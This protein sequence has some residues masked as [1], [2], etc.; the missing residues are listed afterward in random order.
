MVE[1]LTFEQALDKSGAAKRNLLLGNGFSIACDPTIFNYESLYGEAATVIQERMPEVHKL[2]EAQDTKDFEAIIR[3]LEH[4]C[5]VLPCYLTTD[6]ETTSKI[7][8]HSNQLKELLIATIA[9]NHP[10]FPANIPNEK[11]AA[12]RRFLAHFISPQADG[13]AYTLNY[14]LLLYW[15]LMH[16][17]A[18]GEETIELYINDGFGKEEPDSDYIIWKNEDHT[19]DQRVFYL[20]GAVHLFDSGTE[21]EKYTWINSGKRLIEQA[22]EALQNSKFPLFVAEGKSYAK[23]EKIKHQP[24]LHH[25]Y[26]SFLSATKEDRRRRDAQKSLF[27]FG[28]SLDDNDDHIISK[29]TKGSISNLFISIFG[30]PESDGNRRIIGK[31]LALKNLRDVRYPLEVSFYNAQSAQVWG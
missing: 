28:H 29:I 4:A 17:E 11:F 1:I 26:K 2:F 18:D 7:R 27:I 13:R 14:D 23:L 15:V 10:E 20:H 12:C 9:Q 8:D 22:R 6:R 5:S 30:N 3:M 24:Y 31:A 19:K 16:K 25:S 21:L